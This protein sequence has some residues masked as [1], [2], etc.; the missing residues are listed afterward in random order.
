M[1]IYQEDR[2]KRV[3]FT[4]Y[5]EARALADDLIGVGKMKGHDERIRVRLEAT[6]NFHVAVKL[7]QETK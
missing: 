3:V 2:S 1:K 7:P 6:G 5:A 4:S